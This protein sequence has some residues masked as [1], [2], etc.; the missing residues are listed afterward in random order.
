MTH[1]VGDILKLGV[2]SIA[3]RLPIRNYHGDKAKVKPQMV[4]VN[5]IGEVVIGTEHLR[6]LE[7]AGYPQV[8]A[9]IAPNTIEKEKRIK[10]TE[11]RGRRDMARAVL[12]WLF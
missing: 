12:R 6:D 9:R 2:Q 3:G 1:K 8:I 11:I 7:E 4:I 5:E 10:I